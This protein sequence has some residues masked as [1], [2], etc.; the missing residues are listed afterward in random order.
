MEQQLGRAFSRDCR[1]YDFAYLN[2]SVAFTPDGTLFAAFDARLA[3]V[4]ALPNGPLEPMRVDQLAVEIEA[5]T[6]AVTNAWYDGAGSYV[7]AFEDGFADHAGRANGVVDERARERRA[8][9]I[10]RNARRRAPRRSAGRG[11]SA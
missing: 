6:E 2:P 10:A 7:R 4:A 3:Q 1:A 9:A 11:A 8:A 5:V